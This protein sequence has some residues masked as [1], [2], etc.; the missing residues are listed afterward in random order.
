MSKASGLWGCRVSGSKDARGFKGFRV[1][2]AVEGSW[3]GP[4]STLKH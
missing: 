1:W 4:R 3:N 2:E